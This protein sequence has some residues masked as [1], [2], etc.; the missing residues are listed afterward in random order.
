MDPLAVRGDDPADESRVYLCYFHVAAPSICL[1]CTS[2]SLRGCL[3]DGVAYYFVQ[4]GHPFAKALDI[5]A[6]KDAQRFDADELSAGRRILGR[7]G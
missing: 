2:R 3:V 6:A 4:R 7:M 5:D 1:R